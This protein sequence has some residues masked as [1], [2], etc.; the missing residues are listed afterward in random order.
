MN[1]WRRATFWRNAVLLL[2]S[3]IRLGEGD[4]SAGHG[5]HGTEG[6]DDTVEGEVDDQMLVVL[7]LENL[8]HGFG[9]QVF[10]C[11]DHIVCAL[12]A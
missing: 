9:R 5:E 8:G 12:L 10:G 7:T 1:T 3:Y 6:A 2:V 4:F 11:C